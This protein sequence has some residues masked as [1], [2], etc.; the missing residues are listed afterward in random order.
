MLESGFHLEIANWA[1][2]Q[3]ALREVRTSVFIIE[4]QIPPEEEFDELDARSVHVLARDAAGLPIGTAR[5][6]PDRMIGRVAVVRD[7]RGRGVGDALMRT[8]IEQA[9][10]RHWPEVSLHAQVYAIAFYERA[11]FV[12]DGEEFLEAGIP[13]RHMRREFAPPERGVRAGDALVSAAA[14]RKVEIETLDQ[15]IRF[16]DELMV[17]ARHK[18]WIYTRDLDRLLYDREAFLAALRRIALS[19]RG[20]EIQILVHDAADAVRDGHRLLHLAAKLP[21]YIHLRKV[22][23][24]EDRQ[25]PSAFLLT[26]TGGFYTR[27]IG[28]R[29]DGDGHSAAPGMQAGMR[30]YFGQVW[31]R[32]EADPELRRLSV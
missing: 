4:Q 15:A 28:S 31:Q 20:A 27:P 23:A 1:S 5:L 16:V 32:S 3:Q 14:P 12:V 9:Q 30:Y 13:H 2:D 19:G 24:E 25:Y 26:D 6:T 18:V 29:Y 10:A 8:L 7:W 22:S 17:H 21:T 11:G